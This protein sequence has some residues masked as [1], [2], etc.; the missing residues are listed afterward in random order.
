MSSITSLQ[1]L[2]ETESTRANPHIDPGLSIWGWEISVY[3]FLGGLV[4]GILILNS[5]ARLTRR[6]DRM[7]AT[8]RLMPIAT[9]PLLALGLFALFL[10][11][12]YQ[13]H[14][15]RF[16]TTFQVSSPMSWGAWILLVVFATSG[17][18]TLQA[19]RAQGLL[20]KGLFGKLPIPFKAKLAD[21]ADNNTRGLAVANF[22]LGV[23]LGI[24]TGILASS[25]GARPLWSS[26]VLGLLFLAS[27]LSSGAAAA[28]LFAK[29]HEEHETLVR[30]DV[31]LISI[32]AVL[33]VLWLVG[34]G[35]GA[36]Q[37]QEALGL[38][39]GGPFTAVF[40]LLVVGIGIAL[41]LLLEGMALAGK[42]RAARVAPLLVLV[43]GLSLRFVIIEAG[44][45]SAIG[46]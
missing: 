31:A 16:Y 12:E 32:E 11:L 24:Y 35:T 29:K 20:E 9:M 36:A 19:L 14:V 40:W 44:Q 43:G 13:L 33:I 23:A 28:L 2:V 38:L 6:E 37:G 10:D 7:P 21:F 1:T 41:P 30:G 18:A 42:W 45:L 15:F 34:L 22:G 17:L 3:L 26:S 8:T 4:A 27:G 39:L 5:W 25:L 46:G